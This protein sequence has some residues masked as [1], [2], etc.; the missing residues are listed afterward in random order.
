MA[1][2]LASMRMTE[3]EDA[4]RREGGIVDLVHLSGWLDGAIRYRRTV[5]GAIEVQLF[6][7]SVLDALLGRMPFS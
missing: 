2:R 6:H 7:R 4:V 1:N 3:A 5:R